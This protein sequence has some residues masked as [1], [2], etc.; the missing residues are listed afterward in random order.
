[1]LTQ[2]TLTAAAAEVGVHPRTMSRWFDEE[3]FAK[4]YD[5]QMTELQL[6]L[7]RRILQIRAEV[8]DRFLELMRSPNEAIALRATTWVLEKMLS[9]PEVAR[10]SATNDR[11]V[12]PVVSPRLSALL[13]A[14]EGRAPSG[15]SD[16][17]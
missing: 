1:L 16:V 10:R 3:P 2:P 12:D 17:A 7:W 6:E 8:W 11:G 4:E 15:E 13:D 14:A 9:V 5:E